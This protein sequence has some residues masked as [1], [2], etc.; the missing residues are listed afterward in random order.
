MRSSF[1]RPVIISAWLACAE[2]QLCPPRHP[3]PRKQDLTEKQGLY[4]H[5]N[6]VKALK[7]D[8]LKTGVGAGEA[9]LRGTEGT[10]V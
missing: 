8:A 7:R 6:H 1:C 10:A 9:A 5:N 3:H 2:V 4:R